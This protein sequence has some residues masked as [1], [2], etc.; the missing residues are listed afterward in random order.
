MTLH[1]IGNVTEDLVFRLDRL[2]RDGE[3][4]IA[5]DRIADV[6]GKGLNQAIVAARCG[7]EVHLLA[8]VGRDGAGARARAL[9]ATEPLRA[10]LV[11]TRAATDQS[12]VAVADG[13]KNVII[14]SAASA[15]ALTSADVEAA[16]AGAGPTDGLL[17]QGNL[18]RGTT[19]AA[20]RAGRRQGVATTV[21]P[22]PIRWDWCDLLGL[23]DTVILNRPELAALSGCAALEDGVSALLALGVPRVVVTL[24]A[25]G[26]VAA[27]PQRRWSMPSRPVAAVDTAGAGDTFCGVFLGAELRGIGM[28]GALRAAVEAAALTVT[29][30]GTH[31]AFPSA[32]EIETI[33]RETS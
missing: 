3:T 23:V 12:I 30:H 15:D 13:G 14:S 11:E 18:S 27:S 32:D 5:R 22:S 9:I 29:R 1:V 16:L 6:G 28:D 24:G 26:I 2:P 31:S 8:P 10:S 19:E 17:M 20:L 7:A 33:L 4:L 21:N 25:D